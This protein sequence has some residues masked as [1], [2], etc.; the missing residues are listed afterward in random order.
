MDEDLLVF[1]GQKIGLF[2]VRVVEQITCLSVGQGLLFAVLEDIVHVLLIV[3]LRVKKNLTLVKLIPAKIY[4][5]KTRIIF[6]TRKI[7][8]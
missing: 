8:Y 3:L 6:K 7:N 4:T 5:E 2:F 1:F